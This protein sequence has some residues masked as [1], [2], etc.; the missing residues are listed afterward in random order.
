MTPSTL[1][2]Y[3]EWRAVEKPD[4][5]EFRRWLAAWERWD[6]INSPMGDSERRL[7]RC[8]HYIG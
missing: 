5:P 4:T 7:I 8:G 2:P 1:L 6:L 3:S